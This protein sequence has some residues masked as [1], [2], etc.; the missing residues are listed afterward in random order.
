MKAIRYN[1]TA[2]IQ[3]N[4]IETDYCLES[5]LHC[6]LLLQ[7]VGKHVFDLLSIYTGKW[8]DCKSLE[9]EYLKNKNKN[10]ENIKD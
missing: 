1:E 3:E 8:I 10:H 2:H 4:W 6:H 9:V 7:R 5:S